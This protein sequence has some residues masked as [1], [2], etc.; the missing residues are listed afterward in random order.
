MWHYFDENKEKIGPFSGRELKQLALQGT[1][2]PETFVEDPSG[3]TGL[4][5]DVTGLKFSDANSHNTA[6]HKEDSSVIVPVSS[7]ST[8]NSSANFFYFD[9]NGYKYGP[10]DWQKLR[11]LAAQGGIGR[12]TP[13]EADTGH[14]GIAGDILCPVNNLLFYG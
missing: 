10:V 12:T 2:T 5:K 8:Q 6:Q 3:R 7:N 14:K 13:I 11:E 4:A 9:D 1:V